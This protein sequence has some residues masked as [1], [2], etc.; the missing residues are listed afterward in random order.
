MRLFPSKS[1]IY[2]HNSKTSCF[3][4]INLP[5]TIEKDAFYDTKTSCFGVGSNIVFITT[6]EEKGE[7]SRRYRERDGMLQGARRHVAGSETACC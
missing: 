3:G 6:R 4:V 5:L 7:K 2:H 1:I